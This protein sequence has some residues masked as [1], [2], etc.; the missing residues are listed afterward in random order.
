[1]PSFES[2]RFHARQPQKP[3]RRGGRHQG[4]LSPAPSDVVDHVEVQNQPEASTRS[5]NASPR[6][7]ERKVQRRGTCCSTRATTASRRRRQPAPDKVESVPHSDSRGR[8]KQISKKA[9]PGGGGRGLDQL[10]RRQARACEPQVEDAPGRDPT[11]RLGLRTQPMTTHSSGRFTPGRPVARPTAPR[12]C[13]GRRRR[14]A[15]RHHCHR[16]R[17]LG[18]R[19]RHAD[20]GADRKRAHRA[21]ADARRLCGGVPGANGSAGTAPGA[22]P[23]VRRPP[24][25]PRGRPHGSR[26]G[27][28]WQEPG[29]DREIEPSGHLTEQVDDGRSGRRRTAGSGSSNRG[30]GRPLAEGRPRPDGKGTDAGRVEDQTNERG[31]LPPGPTACSRSAAR[32]SSTL[33]RQDADAGSGPRPERGG[34]PLGQ[35]VP[36]RCRRRRRPRRHRR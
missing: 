10:Q 9:L 24:R 23:V 8:A 7:E 6:L 4:R 31:L 35:G 34:L 22:L 33:D 19:P 12:T 28:L 29:R 2:R 36:R 17:P 26:P 18:R 25:S 27:G 1:M 30:P 16:H 32:M 15:A 20:R 11:T 3:T 13:R 5:V 21:Q 14:S